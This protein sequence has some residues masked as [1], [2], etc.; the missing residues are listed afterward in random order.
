LTK[1]LLTALTKRSTARATSR[2][3]VPGVDALRE[4]QG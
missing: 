4:N 2:K 3:F 1:G